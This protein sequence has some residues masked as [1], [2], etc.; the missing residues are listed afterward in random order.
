[1]F[2]DDSRWAL[3]VQCGYLLCPNIIMG[4]VF[5]LWGVTEGKGGFFTVTVCSR[6]ITVNPRVTPLIPVIQNK[7]HVVQNNFDPL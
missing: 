7:K 2:V 1:M 6:C 5:I 4:L 3:A